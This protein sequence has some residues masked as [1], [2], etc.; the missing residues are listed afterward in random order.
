MTELFVHDS[1]LLS[2]V[3]VAIISIMDGYRQTEFSLGQYTWKA[4]LSR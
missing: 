2:L 1:L 4:E 3:T